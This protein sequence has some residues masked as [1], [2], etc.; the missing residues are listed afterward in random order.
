M[1]CLDGTLLFTL[2]QLIVLTTANSTRPILLPDDGC[3]CDRTD[4][5]IVCSNNSFTYGNPCQLEC[6]SQ[7]RIKRGESK[8]IV[9]YE[10]ECD[11]E[12]CI[13]TA[14][15]TPVCGTDGRTY[16]NQ[17][18]LKCNSDKMQRLGNEEIL[19]KN[20]GECPGCGNCP[21]DIIPCCGSDGVTYSSSCSIDCINKKRYQLGI[22]LITTKPGACKYCPCP[23]DVDQPVCGT[24]GRTYRNKCEL[25]CESKRQISFGNP[26]IKVRSKG[27]CPDNT[28]NCPQDNNPV[29]GSNDHTYGNE[30]ELNCANNKSQ[31]NGGS[32]IYSAY[33]GLCLQAPCN[34]SS[35]IAPV[36]GSNSKSYRNI[37]WLDCAS[38]NNVNNGLPRI[39]LKANEVC[40]TESCVCPAIWEPVCG[41]DGK[42]YG[43]K[44]ALQ[45]HNGRRFAIG[46]DL[47]VVLY[48][49]ECQPCNCNKIGDPVCGSD[50]KTYGNPCEIGC[51]NLRRKLR[52]LAPLTWIKEACGC[53]CP[54][55]YLPVC[56][57]D[58]KTYGNKCFLGC[59]NK[60]RSENEEA[61]LTISWIGECGCR[62]TDMELPVCGTD[63]RT[64][65][66]MCWLNC[67]SFAHLRN[68]WPA[69]YL[70]NNG[71]C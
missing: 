35:T 70:R 12:G 6:E 48:T 68:G 38:Q 11:K 36:C 45:C 27:K 7:K 44:C 58:L 15:V 28:C 2:L 41:S 32:P 37:C 59:E 29:C 1:H 46:L 20:Q 30:C 67:A 26:A 57:S 33:K 61:P 54:L 24:D 55:V 16:E 10:G 34:C 49:G 22:P 17:C 66:N 65:R 51:E 14:D 19:V 69:I 53:Y 25:E 71:P 63:I 5:S 43:N 42:T 31:K 39:Y 9:A 60:R 13:C 62:C 56:A 18:W 21:I 40:Y 47:V 3:C 50:G 23:K 8:I 4:F 52:G 64:Y